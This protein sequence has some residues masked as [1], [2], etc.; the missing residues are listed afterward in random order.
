MVVRQSGLKLVNKAQPPISQI[1]ILLTRFVALLV[2]W[3][4]V[5]ALAAIIDWVADI[6]IWPFVVIWI[7]AGLFVMLWN[8]RHHPIPDGRFVD[9]PGALRMLLWAARWPMQI[10]KK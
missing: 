1:Q 6:Q 4:V 3:S 7:R 8:P 5:L 2:A 10:L 9:V